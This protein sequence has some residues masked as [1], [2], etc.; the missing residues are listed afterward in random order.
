MLI[1]GLLR[2]ITLLVDSGDVPTRV[3]SFSLSLRSPVILLWIQ[4]W[5]AVKTKCRFCIKTCLHRGN[6]SLKSFGLI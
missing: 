5:K 3:L 2:A 6:W 4:V 1:L